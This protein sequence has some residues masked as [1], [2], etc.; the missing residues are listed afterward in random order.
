MQQILNEA[1]E[2]N[3]SV[4]IDAAWM[5]CADGIE[6]SFDHPAIQSVAFSLSK[7]LA[8]DWNRVG[9][10]YSRSI[11]SSDAIT[12]S[13]KFKTI[14]SIDISVGVLYMDKFS[15]SYLWTKYGNLYHSACK[16]FL[17]RPTKC[18]HMAKHFNTGQPY[19][20]RDV[21]LAYEKDQ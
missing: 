3:I 11:D 1:L 9:V 12:I 17:L 14:N 21:F 20:F 13:N 8:L 6:F 18:I 15:Q 4:Y 10:R 2:K 19:S 7:G 5:S 16:A